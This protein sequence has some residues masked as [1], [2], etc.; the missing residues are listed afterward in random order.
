MTFF[1]PLKSESNWPWCSKD[2]KGKGDPK[3]RFTLTSLSNPRRCIG[4]ARR[5]MGRGGRVILD[6]I[7]TDYDDLWRTLDFS[8]VE[9][10]KNT[11]PSTVPSCFSTSAAA[12][13]D[14]SVVVKSEVSANSCSAASS[15]TWTNDGYTVD[16]SIFSGTSVSRNSFSSDKID[17]T[18]SA[19]NCN[20]EVKKEQIYVKEED[21]VTPL[22]D[23]QHQQ[24]IEVKTEEDKDEMV[25]FLR[26]L[27]RDW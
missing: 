3:Y 13:G 25:E 10:Q 9:P 24:P 17:S 20:F 12:I 15:S 4:F 19:G 22:V 2:E 7:S 8:I 16:H 27:R 14:G 6:R 11:E 5:R 1:Q 21:G 18:T 26:S 23:V